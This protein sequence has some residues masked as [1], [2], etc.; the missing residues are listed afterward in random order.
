MTQPEIIQIIAAVGGQL[1]I[2]GGGLLTAYFK[3]RGKV[4][5][6]LEEIRNHTDEV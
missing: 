5:E 6:R 4:D 1:L 2:V 3:I